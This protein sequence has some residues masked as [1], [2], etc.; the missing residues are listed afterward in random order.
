MFPMTNGDWLVTEINGDWVDEMTPS[1]R[2]VWSAHPPGITYPSDTNEVS[3]GIFL[4]VSYTKPGIVEEFNTKGQVLWRYD[5]KGSQMLNK[6]SLALPLPNG[7]VLVNDDWNDRVIVVDPRTDEVLWQYG[8]TGV[9]G[10]APGY[11]F[12]PDG[13]DLV[14]PYSLLMRHASTLGIPP[15]P[16]RSTPAPGTS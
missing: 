6:P 16:V 7:D 5:P 15:F 3:P 12:K 9:A 13:V 14:P 11:L 8:V 1:G 10:S 4:T 2:V